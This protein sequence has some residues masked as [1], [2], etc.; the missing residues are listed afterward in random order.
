[1]GNGSSLYHVVFNVSTAFSLG[2]CPSKVT[3]TYPNYSIAAWNKLK[4]T[5]S[6]LSGSTGTA[7]FQK[8]QHLRFHAYQRDVFSKIPGL[9]L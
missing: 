5:G 2:Q 6:G 1:M 8:L 4:L 9:R 3:A 7:Q